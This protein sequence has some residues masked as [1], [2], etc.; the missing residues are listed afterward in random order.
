[1]RNLAIKG[2][3]PHRS[4][5]LRCRAGRR[6]HDSGS[7]ACRPAVLVVKPLA[8]LPPAQVPIQAT[9]SEGAGQARWRESEGSSCAMMMTRM[10]PWS[11]ETAESVSKVSLLHGWRL[12][13]AWAERKREGGFWGGLRRLGQFGR[14]P[15]STDP[16][17][18]LIFSRCSS[19]RSGLTLT[20]TTPR[21]TMHTM[22]YLST[23][24]GDDLLSFEDVSHPSF[25]D[26]ASFRLHLPTPPRH[27][28]P[29]PLLGRS[30]R[31]GRRNWTE[32]ED[33]FHGGGARGEHARARARWRSRP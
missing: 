20:S 24:G 27:K 18:E 12:R 15:H 10:A 26:D 2:Q 9:G 19:S 13:T 4:R 3:Y 32:R 17:K 21:P 6:R 22:K 31:L 28:R 29:S 14:D 8:T 33:F 5:E 11:L 7:P 16:K 25:P 30:H 1:M 23:R